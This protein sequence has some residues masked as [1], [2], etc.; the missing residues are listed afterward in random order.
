MVIG[1]RRL[2][3]LLVLLLAVPVMAELSYREDV[4]G[5]AVV[6]VT[7]PEF[8][9]PGRNV[10]VTIVFTS[11]KDMDFVVWVLAG[12]GWGRW[13]NWTKLLKEHLK[14]LEKRILVHRVAIPEDVETGPMI[15]VLEVQYYD[16]EHYRVEG[17]QT[18]YDYTYRIFPGPYIHG[19]E[20]RP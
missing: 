5:V 13:T 14:P 4:D 12:Y 7:M 1:L 11:K 6:D 20:P 15:V 19:T 16:V 3:L 2:G 8:A 17:N 9:S 10:T 18:Y